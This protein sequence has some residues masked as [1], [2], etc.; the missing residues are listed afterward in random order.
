[1]RDWR[2]LEVLVLVLVLVLVCDKGVLG[3]GLSVWL[4]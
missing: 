4:G 3:I 1:M 2:L